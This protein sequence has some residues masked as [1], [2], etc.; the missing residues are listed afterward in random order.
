LHLLALG[1]ERLGHHHLGER[2]LDAVERAH[3]GELRREAPQDGL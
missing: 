3:P 2:K 1:G